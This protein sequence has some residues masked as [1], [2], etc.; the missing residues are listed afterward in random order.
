MR[1][2]CSKL[3][4]AAKAKGLRAHNN[5]ITNQ[6]RDRAAIGIQV[7]YSLST[8]FLSRLKYRLLTLSATAG[9]SLATSTPLCIPK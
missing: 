6:S 2:L 7:G 8:E 9:S 1:N 4:G 3:D 5:F